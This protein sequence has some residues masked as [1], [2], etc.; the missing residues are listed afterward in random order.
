MSVLHA[1]LPY[2]MSV[3]HAALPYAMSVLQRALGRSSLYAMSVLH[4]ALA[5][6]IRYASTAQ[7]PR[8]H[9]VSVPHCVILTQPHTPCRY[10][11]ARSSV[12]GEPI[13][14]I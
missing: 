7:C 6:T 9:A 1:A 12:L 3:L 8:P 4:T 2:A 13:S 11:T 14:D 10:R 5:S